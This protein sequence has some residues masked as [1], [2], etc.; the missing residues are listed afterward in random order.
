M[1]HIDVRELNVTNL[2]FGDGSFS[3]VSEVSFKK[4]KYAY[5]EFYDSSFIEKNNL[6]KR[7]DLL[8]E[9]KLKQSAVAEYI[10]DS[11]GVSSGY[12]VPS[13]EKGN[14]SVL[15]KRIEIYKSLL[16]IR[17]AIIELHR[18]NIVHGDIHVGNLL[19]KNNKGMLIDFDNCRILDNSNIR[20]NIKIF[21][22]PAKEYI[23]RKG[24]IKNLDIYMFNI[25]TF[26]LLNGANFRSSN[27]NLLFEKVKN[28][29]FKEEYGMFFRKEA[30]NICNMLC[31]YEANDFLIDSIDKKA[32]LQ[33][34]KKISFRWFY[35]IYW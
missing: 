10:V 32:V 21:S 14:L 2:F 20:P 17:D 31:N 35:E 24:I 8:L 18:N 11:N 26:S 33:Y 4:E 16:T 34:E 5:K 25:L 29:I 3:E 27:I 13:L 28:G 12:L 9:R 1:I 19:F 23:K 22:N 7:F 6:E 30:R 15:N